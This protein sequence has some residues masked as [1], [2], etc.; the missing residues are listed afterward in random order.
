MCDSIYSSEGT[1]RKEGHTMTLEMMIATYAMLT[2]SHKYILGFLV[3]NEL[4]YI[5][6]D[7]ATL[8]QYM[9]LDRES[10][11]RGGKAKVRIRMTSAQRKQLLPLATRCGTIEDLERLKKY[12]RGD[13]FEKLIYDIFAPQEHWIKNSTPFNIA[14]DITI[15][16]EQVQ[17]KL[18]SAELVTEKYLTELTAR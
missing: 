3:K 8:V 16:G 7:L 4:Y 5:F 15:N 1:G 18:D 6:A 2:A 9:K 11:K 10:S 12:N 17:I 14:G 13:N